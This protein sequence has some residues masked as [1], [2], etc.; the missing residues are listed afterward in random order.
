M[1]TPYQAGLQ[2]IK[3]EQTTVYPEVHIPILPANLLF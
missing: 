2:T 3:G 1:S